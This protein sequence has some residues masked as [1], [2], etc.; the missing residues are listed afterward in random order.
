MNVDFEQIKTL[1]DLN[2]FEEYY[3]VFKKRNSILCQ[4]CILFK[5]LD[6]PYD[7]MAK[8]SYCL[9]N[10]DEIIF[11]IN[12]EECEKKLKNYG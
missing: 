9:K 3:K 7:C 12:Y 6:L 5:E 1:H 11:I 2:I 8:P 10:S 4:K